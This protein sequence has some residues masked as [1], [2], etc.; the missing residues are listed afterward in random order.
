MACL[1]PERPQVREE[2][3]ELIQLQ[4]ENAGTRQTLGMLQ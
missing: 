1:A 3:Q 2:L 4:S